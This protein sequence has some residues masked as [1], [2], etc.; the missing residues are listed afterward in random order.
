MGR[1]DWIDNTKCIAIFLVVFGHFS[2]VPDSIINLVYSFH[3]PVFI[4]ITGFLLE[5]KF[6]SQPNSKVSILYIQISNLIVYFLIFSFFSI[7]IFSFLLLLKGQEIDLVDL[8]KRTLYGVHGRDKGLAH[9][10]GALWYY[11]FLVSSLFILSLLV[12]L[13]R[14]VVVIVTL[15]L[16]TFSIE[17]DGK[18]L[19]WAMNLAGIGLFYLVAGRQ[20][21]HFYNLS[22]DIFKSKMMLYIA[23]I[24]IPLFCLLAIFN[25][26]TNI[27]RTLFGDN[28]FLF[29]INGIWG[30]LILITLS[31]HIK[32]NYITKL[33]S[34]YSLVIF[35]IHLYFVKSFRFVTQIDNE[36]IRLMIIILLSFLI[37][38]VCALFGKFTMP[39]LNKLTIKK[40]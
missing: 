30:S 29:F 1:Y 3:L 21:F 4:I 5:V 34:T 36:L 15:M 39:Y 11:P 40:K 24:C 26:T 7:L 2:G 12:K 6:N 10:N 28:Y 14:A 22:G 8:L 33:F 20:L 19:F 25:G 32:I 31:H 35:S 18:G 38:Y 9:G 37:S 17:Y 23:I 13:H 16:A 27:N